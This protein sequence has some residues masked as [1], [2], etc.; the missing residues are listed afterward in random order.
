MAKGNKGFASRFGL[1]MCLIGASVGSGNIWRFPRMAALNGGGAFVLAWTI[2]LF[3]VSIPII[4]AEMILG[5]A[6]RHGTPGAFKDFMGKKYTWMG[7]F[8]CLTTVGITSYY[9]AIMSWV[10]QYIILSVTKGYYGKDTTQLFQSIATGN[11]ST[12]LFFVVSLAITAY[13]VGKGISGGIE[14]VN[15][16]MV[17][18]LFILLAI[19]AIRTITLPGAAKG[20]EFYFH[21]DKKSLFSASTWL[22]ALTQS[23]W[24]V[25]PGWG[26]VLTYGIYTKSKSDIA[27]NEFMQGIGDNSAAL[28]AGFAVLPAVFALAPSVEAATEICASGNTGL[29]F[30][31]LTNLLQQIPGGY[32]V[33]IAFFTALYCAAL[34]S[35]IVMF[36]TG[37]AP[38]IDAGWSRKK[39][40]LAIFM[41]C[42]VWGL[43]SALNVSFLNNQDWVFGMVLLIG[44]LFLCGAIIKF[45]T[46]K[47]RKEYINIPENELYIGKWWNWC[48][49]FIAPILIT[50][51][52]VWWSAQAIS[53]YPDNWWDPFLESS[54]GTIILQGGLMVIV[55][56]L[57]NNKISNS[58]KHKYFNDQ[59]Y[60]SIPDE[61]GN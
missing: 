56:M 15:S 57:F 43:P 6:T 1:I 18:T 60:P 22:N 36:L 9:T 38:L 39:A 59:G 14:K 41:V 51:M 21:I 46:E 55:L 34:S 10:L 33:G 37:V 19:V 27:L 23:A 16:I 49:N 32:I 3:L 61:H 20:L 25:G 17:P 29:T 30:I 53:W 47:V 7:A 50:V 4:I 44:S 26:F 24:S 5:R 12:V 13:I 45:G 52:F 58:V 48:I 28:L 42:L 31:T 40:T 35:N 11:M 54:L 8:L 2:M